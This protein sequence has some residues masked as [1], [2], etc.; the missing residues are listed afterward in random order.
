MNVRQRI[1]HGIGPGLGGL[2]TQWIIA[3]GFTLVLVLM[4]MLTGLGLSHMATIK[5]RMVNLVT[6]SN[7][8]T[9]SVFQMRSVSRE[10]FAS[11]GQ[12]VV[13][14]DPFERDEE[15]MRFQAQASEFIRARDRL[16]GLGMGPEEQATWTRARQLIQRDEQLH[17]QV[18]ELAMAGRS[19]TALDLLLRDVRPL[20]NSLLDV[21]NEM[22]E[23][24]RRTNQQSLR[25]SEADYREAAAYMIGLALLALV[26]GLAIAWV[27]IL[28]SRHAESELSRQSEAAIAAAEQLSWA[29]G[30]DSLTGLSNRRETQR[31]LSL[32][33]QDTQAHGMRHVLLYIDLDKFKAVNDS[34]GH[35]AGDE[36]L[37]Q[38]ANIFTRHVRSGDLAAR[39][40]GDEF[41]IGLAN[42]DMGKAR[43]IAEA[44]RD[45]VAQYRFCWE[46][47]VFQVGASVGLVQLEPT[48]D[49]P[50]VLRAA[51]AA[52]YQAKERGRNQVCVH[53]ER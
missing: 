49:V 4:A 19:E 24:Y 52:C 5:A 36:L 30:H 46:D 16:L 39:L 14:R 28:R 9:E 3:I 45:D 17:A 37:R 50:A 32:L 41:C 23:Q 15:Y 48:M 6:E 13:L 42:C 8:K 35:L 20:E 33:V 47:R 10:R 51:D 44:I 29:A 34:C 40:G 27:V 22:V 38:L 25:E 7:V 43:Q 31:H 53:G 21:F 1:E 26:M 18:I 11:L 2:G 12:M